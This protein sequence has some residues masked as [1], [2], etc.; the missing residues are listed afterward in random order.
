SHIPYYPKFESWEYNFYR[1]LSK[2]QLK[3]AFR[4]LNPRVQEY[5]WMGRT[6]DGYRY[7]HC[8]VSERL[9]PLI[10]ECY[11]LHEPRKVRISDHSAMYMKMTSLEGS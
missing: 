3:D 11:Y 5:S 1:S 7:D 4:Y 2:Y 6:G 10:K 9:L 8:F